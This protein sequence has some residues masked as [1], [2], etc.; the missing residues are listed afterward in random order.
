MVEGSNEGRA[1]LRGGPSPVRARRVSAWVDLGRDWISGPGTT[2]GRRFFRSSVAFEDLPSVGA[3]RLLANA[4]F[5]SE[6]SFGS[7]NSSSLP[8]KTL[9]LERLCWP[10]LASEPLAVVFGNDLSLLVLTSRPLRKTMDL[11]M[12]ISSGVACSGKRSGVSTSCSPSRSTERLRSLFAR[13][14][15]LPSV[16]GVPPEGLRECKLHCVPFAVC[17]RCMYRGPL[18]GVTGR[19]AIVGR[20]ELIRRNKSGLDDAVT[21]LELRVEEAEA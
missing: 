18:G 8:C 7:A 6:E 5:L 12:S 9:S 20:V 17:F 2:V 13:P 3:C 14:I 16:F 21:G 19:S 4:M 10:L 1:G 15:E 11:D